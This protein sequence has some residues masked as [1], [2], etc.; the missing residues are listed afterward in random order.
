[1]GA[2]ALP[3]C[4]RQTIVGRRERDRDQ[5]ELHPKLR[6]RIWGRHLTLS[7]ACVQ[8]TTQE[9][10]CV[11]CV[12]SLN[13][14]PGSCSTRG[15]SS[16]SEGLKQQTSYGSNWR[17][18]LPAAVLLVGFLLQSRRTCPNTAGFLYVF[19]P[20]SQPSQ[21]KMPFESRVCSNRRRSVMPR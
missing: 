19:W 11:G 4:I 21:Y 6:R 20:R 5:I 14:C 17:S 7:S 13:V 18:R 9:D 2:A 1:M 3:S 8:E 10:P 12:E 15:N 16:S